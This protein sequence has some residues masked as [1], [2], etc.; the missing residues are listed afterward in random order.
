MLPLCKSRKTLGKSRKEFQNGFT[1]NFGIK[2]E[3]YIRI[4]YRIKRPNGRFFER[5]NNFFEVNLGLMLS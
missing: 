5:N 4:K 1:F 3:I 2:R